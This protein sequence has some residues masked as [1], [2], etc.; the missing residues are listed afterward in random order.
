ML[1]LPARLCHAVIW[2][3]VFV[4]TNGQ[5]PSSRLTR[6]H[7]LE[8]QKLR[9]RLE[10][11]SRLLEKLNVQPEYPPPSPSS[12]SQNMPPT[13]LP[14]GPSWLEQFQLVKHI[15]NSH[16]GVTS[17]PTPINIDRMASIRLRLLE[18]KRKQQEIQEQRV[19]EQKL[20]E[21]RLEKQ[22]LLE[23]KL[24]EQRLQE[25]KLREQKLL[26]QKL[27]EQRLKEQRLQE[28]KLREQKLLEQKLEDQRL[29]EQRMAEQRL[30][31]QRLQKLR[32]QEE[33]LL[34]KRLHELRLQVQGA[35][36]NLRH[37]GQMNQGQIL[38][39]IDIGSSLFGPS[40]GIQVRPSETLIGPIDLGQWNSVG[41]NQFD[42]LGQPGNLTEPP[43]SGLTPDDQ[44]AVHSGEPLGFFNPGE[45]LQ[46]L[47]SSPGEAR[48]VEI[49]LGSVGDSQWQGSLLGAGIPV[50]EFKEVNISTSVDSGSRTGQVDISST[51]VNQPLNS[52]TG[53]NVNRPSAGLQTLNG[54]WMPI[55]E[56]SRAS[57][58]VNS[59]VKN[60]NAQKQP[61]NLLGDLSS[62]LKNR[63][64]H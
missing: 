28:Q 17:T 38:P 64:L 10:K 9:S 57:S 31:E 2:I 1:N 48:G 3:G 30:Q 56:V 47:Q 54:G 7:N 52:N 26:E 37:I 39:G 25:Q 55:A 33:L 23:Q 62:K 51:N 58:S 4:S 59:N 42:P 8:K 24:Q 50:T 21:Q 22:R 63:A 5:E 45:A 40:D 14:V 41:A 34:E 44:S 46:P 53:Q 32:R 12:P 35:S 15:L 13:G 36:H 27:E 11:G 6:W 29:H 61:F 60:K 19:Q 20:L 49:G 43:D 18:K 16:R